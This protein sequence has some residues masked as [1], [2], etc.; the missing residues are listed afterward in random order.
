MKI[1]YIISA[2]RLPDQLIRLVRALS[3]PGVRFLVHLDKRTLRDTYEIV[4]EGFCSVDN[5]QLLDSHRCRWG[6]FGHVRATLKGIRELRRSGESFD[7]AVLLTGQDYPL[8]S[9]PEI[10]ARLA[11]DADAIYMQHRRLPRAGWAGRGG[12]DR[13]EYHY[14]FFGRRP[15]RIKLRR[16]FPR[17]FV[18]FAGSSYWAIPRA[19]VE[20][21]G[22]FCDSNPAFVRYFRTTFIPDE[23]FFHTIL[24]NSPLRDRVVDDDLRYIA[25]PDGAS[26]PKILTTAD[27]PDMMAGGAL[28]ARKF[29]VNVDAEVLSALDQSRGAGMQA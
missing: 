21:I 8:R 10:A 27:L 1:A 16:R 13:V 26:N 5:V 29:D 9:N 4:R 19:G 20:Y 24:M 18:P 25:W 12:L 14:V 11:A 6:D 17:G 2:Y 15:Y 7:Y 22:S 23:T 3:E 28:F